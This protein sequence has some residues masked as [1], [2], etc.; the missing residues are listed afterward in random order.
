MLLVAAM[1]HMY[2]NEACRRCRYESD[3]RDAGT[4]IEERTNQKKIADDLLIVFDEHIGACE[5]ATVGTWP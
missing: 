4:E 2:K 3:L 5:V 1:E